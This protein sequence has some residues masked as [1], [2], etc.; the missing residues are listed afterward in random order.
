MSELSARISGLIKESGTSLRALSKEIGISHVALANW[1]SGKSRPS[2][3]NLEA[4][5]KRFHVSPAWLLFGDGAEAGGQSIQLDDS[6]S[7]PLLEAEGSC[8]TREDLE[9]FGCSIITMV[10]VTYE[11]IRTY[12]PSAAIRSLH[13]ITARGD[14]MSPTLNDGDAVIVDV[15]QRDVTQDGLYAVSLSGATL[16]KRIQITPKGLLL[17]SDNPRYHPIALDEGDSV[18]IIGRVYVGLQ[19]RRLT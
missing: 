16:I 15:S 7:I 1:V 10:R 6:V 11:F 12:C 2:D 19:I 9:Q 17:I 3:E 4:F 5:C 14:S 13:I 18:N 8:G